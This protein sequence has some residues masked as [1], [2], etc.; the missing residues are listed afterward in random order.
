M[1]K[2][3]RKSN[4]KI[5]LIYYLIMEA[6]TKFGTVRFLGTFLFNFIETAFKYPCA[7]ASTTA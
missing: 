2:V 6:L 7:F 4:I 5:Y 1:R 3:L